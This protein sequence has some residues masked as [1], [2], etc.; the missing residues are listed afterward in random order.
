MKE[1]NNIIY[2]CHQLINKQT[3]WKFLF[4]VL[5]DGSGLSPS[6]SIDKA[7][8]GVQNGEENREMESKAKTNVREIERRKESLSLYAFTIPCFMIIHRSD[9]YRYLNAWNRMEID[10]PSLLLSFEK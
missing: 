4:Q 7:L 3:S 5:Q 1:Q 9:P 10:E 6:F 2:I 8:P